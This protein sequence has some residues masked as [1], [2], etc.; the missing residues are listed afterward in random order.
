MTPSPVPPRRRIGLFGGAFDPP[1]LTHVNLAR[2]AV[3]QLGLDELRVLVTGTA[4]HKPRGLSSAVHRI[5]M[6]ELAFSG[7]RKVRVDDRETRRIGPSYTM[8]T[9]AGLQL[10]NPDTDW[11]LILGGD[12]ALALPSWHRIH[13]LLQ[14]ATVCIADRQDSTGTYSRFDPLKW[15]QARFLT[16]QLPPSGQSAT[17]IRAMAHA[18]Q[19]VSPLVGQ[20]VARYIVDHQLYQ[21]SP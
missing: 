1:H 13:D 15:P 18:R 7:L 12:Q 14:C 2:L 8:D 16:L 9:L 3:E 10:E 19:D 17:Q 5:A 11:F 20:A 6:A 21:T 4:W